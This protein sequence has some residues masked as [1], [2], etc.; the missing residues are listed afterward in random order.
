[1]SETELPQPH[2]QE[3]SIDMRAAAKKIFAHFRRREMSQTPQE[4]AWESEEAMHVAIQEYLQRPRYTEPPLR[5][6]ESVDIPTVHGF[7]IFTKKDDIW[8][9][10]REAAEYDAFLFGEEFQLKPPPTG[11]E[12]LQSIQKDPASSY[13]GE[14]DFAFHEG[15]TVLDL[16]SGEAVALHEYARMYPNTTFIGADT[17]YSQTH[18]LERGVPGVQ[19]VQDD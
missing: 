16:G 8:K 14:R 13:N 4:P 15:K 2:R 9:T 6:G 17:G 1:M 11:T 10:N 3:Q 7:V 19:L 18:T 5:K 12:P